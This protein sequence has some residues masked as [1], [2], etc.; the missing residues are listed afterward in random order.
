M[1]SSPYQ[2]EASAKAIYLAPGGRHKLVK[3]TSH[4]RTM[5]GK[6]NGFSLLFNK[7]ITTKNQSEPIAQKQKL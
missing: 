3:F 4:K 7:D 2:S 5:E 6:V 1:P